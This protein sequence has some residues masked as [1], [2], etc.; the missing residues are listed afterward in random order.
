MNNLKE[1]RLLQTPFIRVEVEVV[2]NPAL[3]SDKKQIVKE[4][5]YKL[6]PSAKKIA[7]YIRNQIFGSDLILQ[8]EDYNINWLM[9][10]LKE[11]LENAI[12]LK[13]S[14]IYLHKFDGKI[15]LECIKP[16]QIF[17]L[18]QKYDKIFSCRIIECDEEKHVELHRFIKLENGKSYI[19]LK[20]YRID[21]RNKEYEISIDEYNRIEG[22]ELL[23]TYILPY[24]VII[25]IDC[26]EEFFKDSKKLLNEEMNILNTIADEVEKTKTR[27]ATS[28][29]YQSNVVLPQWKPTTNFNVEQLSVGKLADY[30]TLMPGDKDHQIFEFLQGNVRTNDY[31]NTFKFYDYQIIQMAGLS[32][33]TFGYE[34][35][36]YQNTDNVNLNA[37]A[38][39]MTIEAIKTQIEP[40]I[41]NLLVNI[42]RM[43]NTQ[44]IK[45]QMLPSEL[46]WNYGSNERLD[47]QKKL[48]LLSSIQKVASVPYTERA[49]IIAPILQKLLDDDFNIDYVEELVKGRNEERGNLRVEYGEL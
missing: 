44:D 9:P 45:E 47:D 49:K 6:V 7:T 40:Q 3:N 1:S 27:I 32:P 42:V 8:A 41:N 15:Y 33:M 4:Y 13:E 38:S 5:K 12:Y 39:E 35:D 28:T 11:A 2:N 16:N 17:D 37:N 25:N 18:V 43:Q 26:G 10:T 36:S 22:T 31:V 20:A 23:P 14:F 46:E 30:F 48:K 19:T 29:H 21:E 24:E 34:K